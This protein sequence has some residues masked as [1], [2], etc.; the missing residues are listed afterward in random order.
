VVVHGRDG[1]ESVGLGQVWYGFLLEASVSKVVKLSEATNAAEG[2][3]ELS[4]PWAC[5]VEI[6]GSADVLFHR[7]QNEVVAEKAAAR[8]GSAA[9]KTDNVESYVYRDEEGFICLPGEYLRGAIIGASKFRQDPRSPR[10]SAMDLFKAGIISLTPLASLG[11]K[12]WDYEDRRRVMIQRNGVTRVRPA[13][14]KGWKCSIDLMVNVPEYIDQ[15]FLL[16]VI[17]TAGRLI[18]VADFRPTYGRFD[19]TGFTKI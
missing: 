10:K 14:R 3:I 19:L 7:W 9:K 16:D 11:V 2:S 13:L 8:K 6:T 15:A 1:R 17:G 4:Q 5:T 12:E 18:G